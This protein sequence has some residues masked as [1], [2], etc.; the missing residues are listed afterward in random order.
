MTDTVIL[1]IMENPPKQNFPHFPGLIA[2]GHCCGGVRARG[3]VD[4]RYIP[5]LSLLLATIHNTQAANPGQ[6]IVVFSVGDC[7]HFCNEDEAALYG[8]IRDA[9]DDYIIVTGKRPP[10]QLGAHIIVK[11]AIRYAI[12]HQYQLMQFQNDDCWN[13]VF[14]IVDMSFAHL[15]DQGLKY[16]GMQTHESNEIC[17]LQ[18]VC[19]P[20]AWEDFLPLVMRPEETLEKVMYRY[21]TEYNIPYELVPLNGPGLHWLHIGHLSYYAGKLQDTSSKA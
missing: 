18:F 8:Q 4:E 14:R 21:V 7:D 6:K 2:I 1:P 10:H 9:V 3:V 16:F 11:A 19:D 5:K 13:T 15:V 12:G 20:R 17:S